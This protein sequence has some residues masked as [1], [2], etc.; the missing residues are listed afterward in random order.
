M[1]DVDKMILEHFV[2]FREKVV[3]AIQAKHPYFVSMI[4]HV[5]SGK[6]NR[7]GL[8]VTENGQVV[9]EYTFELNGIRIKH[10]EIG[11]IDP[12]VHHP[13]LG[14]LKPCIL[15]ERAA[16]EKAINDPLFMDEPFKAISKLLPN[17]TITFLS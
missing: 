15:I 6:R 13:V 14:I 17:I 1:S 16:V 12:E 8:R 10:T 5:L 9:G 11:K 4:E 3:D 2:P 7:L